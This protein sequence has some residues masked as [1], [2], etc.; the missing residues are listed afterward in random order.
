MLL[1]RVKEAYGDGKLQVEWHDFP[2]EQVNSVQGPEWKLWEQPDDYR[3]KGLWAFR[4]GEAAKLQGPEAFERF[5]LALL[6]ARHV[7]RKDV[8]DRSVLL[9][10]ARESGLDVGKFESDLSDRG[11]MAKIG[12]DYSRAVEEYGIWGTP[13]LVFEGGESAYLR[14]RPDPPEEESVRVFEELV[15][16]IRDR[17]YLLELKRPRG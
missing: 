16:A 14:M 3:S 15:D 2:L 9:D 13:T 11:L 4:A 6:T 7:D 8:A 1:K 12:E 5:H 10:V 17:P